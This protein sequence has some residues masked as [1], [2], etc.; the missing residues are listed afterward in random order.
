MGGPQHLSKCGSSPRGTLAEL[1]L[2]TRSPA[3]DPVTQ[4]FQGIHTALFQELHVLATTNTLLGPRTGGFPYGQLPGAG[5][6]GGFPSLPLVITLS[7]LH[8]SAASLFSSRYGF[9]PWPACLCF[10]GVS[11]SPLPTKVIL[12]PLPNKRSSAFFPAA[13]PIWMML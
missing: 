12:A 6:T 10:Q 7:P 13:T 3:K 11:W 2:P 8:L 1:A 5:C 9:L 4:P